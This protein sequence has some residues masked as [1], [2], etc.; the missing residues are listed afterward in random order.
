MPESPGISLILLAGTVVIIVYLSGVKK[1]PNGLPYPPGPTT[2]YPILGNLLDI[3]T[4]SPW[5][6]YKDMR[7][8]YGK[9][10]FHLWERLGDE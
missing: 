6:A 7:Q 8:Q 4:K 2:T 1:R 3:P 9:T 5:L 10:F